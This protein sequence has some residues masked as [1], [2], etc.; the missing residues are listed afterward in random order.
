MSGDSYA[1]GTAYNAE[2]AK[3]YSSTARI[4][5]SIYVRHW[6]YWLDTTFKA[7][8]SG[9]LNKGNVHGQQK[10]QPNGA[11]NN[12]VYQ[13]KTLESPVPPYFDTAD[14]D[15]SPNG[16]WVAF[17]SKAPQLPKAN[18]TASYI[19][20]AP[21]DGS[22][23]PVAINGPNSRGTPQ[24][25]EGASISPS[26]SP[27]SSRIA[28][29]QMS[30]IKYES[31]RTILYVYT[32]GSDTISSVAKNWD[33]SPGSVKWAANGKDLFATASDLGRGRL[34]SLPVAAGDNY[35][36]KN[37]TDGGSV[38][39]YHQLPD[40]SL[41]VTGTAI[42]TNWNVYTASLQNGVISTIASANKIDPEL[43]DLSPSDT[44]EFWFMGNWTNVCI[45]SSG[46]WHANIP[47][48]IFHYLPQGLR[49]E[50]DLSPP[51]LHPWWSAG[52]LGRCLEFS[53]ES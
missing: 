51:L 9:V 24:G 35:E 32:I 12:L 10:Y 29:G 39:E 38:S 33:R 16:Q 36:P 42:W 4:Y 30:D 5:D 28:H 6:D 48:P 40:S 20:L 41:L 43:M 14:Y 44:D 3:T 17:L 25:V 2:S 52:R 27:D 31:D 19:Y 13:I 8:F 49:Q 15:L 11:L 21:H 46:L 47:A 34:F 23:K 1:D 26:F 37:F 7:V 22:A 50:Q 45:P 53:V 18:F